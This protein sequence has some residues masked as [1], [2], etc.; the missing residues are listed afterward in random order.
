MTVYDR[1][2]ALA[3]RLI[4]AKGEVCTWRRIVDGVPPDVNKPWE[5][6]NSTPIDVPGVS[7]VFL[8]LNR[9]NTELIRTLAG[10]DLKTG[11][12]YGLMATVPFVPTTT[13]LVI[14]SDGR[15]ARIESIDTLEPDGT[16]ILYTI[17]FTL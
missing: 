9:I 10:S 8:P 11:N 15:V 2:I 5:V 12:A 17:N 3:T 6:A 16:P 7:I 1:H 14:R 4:L 13:D